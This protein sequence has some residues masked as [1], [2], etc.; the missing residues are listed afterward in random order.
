M[1]T[2]PVLPVPL[3]L[4][5][6]V[7]LLAFC[8]WR[9]W[10]ERRAPG[11][12]GTSL[13]RSWL[14]RAGL[15][16]LVVA[17]AFRPG[18]PG[19]GTTQNASAD[20]DVFFVVDTTASIVAEDYGGAKP[21]LDGVRQDAA[22]LVA[23]LPGARFSLITFDSSALTRLPLTGDATAVTTAME[24]LRP[25]VTT[26]SRGSSVTVAAPLLTQQLERARAAHPERARV[27]FYFG[28]GE[29][30][31][32]QA[33]TPFTVPSGAVNGGAVLGYGTAAGGRMKANEGYVAGERAD[34]V[35]DRSVTPAVDA[36]SVIDEDRL[37]TVAGQLGVPYTHRSAG[38]PIEHAL[39][40]TDAGRL[41]AQAGSVAG[42]YEL[43]WILAAAAVGIVARE[44]YLLGADL[45]RLA[46]RRAVSRRAGRVRVP[47][48]ER[49]PEVT[50]APR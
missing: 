3:L 29:Q 47:V 9:W 4:V 41:A 46:P 40:A 10:A 5:A 1:T 28:D 32:G 43:Y 2:M 34:Y 16:A 11:A 8:A 24:V 14:W 38:D 48:S 50:D 18:I 36:K 31:D 37:R 33:P 42:R 25:E 39:T 17:A 23:A 44:L 22:R 13:S 12:R 35:Q 20:L 21:R 45:L 27:V 26:Y 30:T 15:V 19:A 49:L 6:G 7:A